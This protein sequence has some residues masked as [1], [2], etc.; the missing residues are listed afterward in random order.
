MLGQLYQYFGIVGLASIVAWGVALGLL[1]LGARQ[2]RRQYRYLVALGL[3]T[4]ALVLAHI[5]SR[6]VSAIDTDRTEELQAARRRQQQ[7][8]AAE[9]AAAGPRFAED[10]APAD[11]PAVPAYRLAGKQQR[12]GGKK[13][14]LIASDTEPAAAAKPARRMMKEA[15]VVRANRLDRYNL[16]AARSTLGLV[17][18]LVLWDYVARFN[19]TFESW[20]PLPIGGKWLDALS[21]KSHSVF[22]V[23]PPERFCRDLL[24]R[25][26]RRGE[27]FIYCGP[28]DPCPAPAGLPRLAI[29]RKVL[30]ALATLVQ[31]DDNFDAEFVLESAWFGR[32]GVVVTHPAAVRRLWQQLLPYLRIRQLTRATAPHTVNLLWNLPTP[33]PEPVLHELLALTRE[34]NFRL[35]ISSPQP[36]SP[37]L[38]AQFEEV[39]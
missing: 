9:T 5:N 20:W 6:A 30:S 17:L 37:A 32:Y 13:Q 12:E 38:A 34:T 29:G 16:L 14:P 4:L 39:R 24:E 23:S 31:A 26:V 25:V 2:R 1:V 3:A 36:P 27:T 7:A 22:L 33:P 10:A 35:I 18:L 11:D 15:D 8:R 28:T 19:R 21:H